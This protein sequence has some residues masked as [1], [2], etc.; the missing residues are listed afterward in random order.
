MASYTWARRGDVNC[1]FGLMLDNLA[2]M[3]ILVTTLAGTGLFT[4]SFILT[5]MIPGTALGVLIGDLVFTWLAFRLARRTGRADVTAM[6][7]GLDTPSTFGVALLVL[8][9]A[10]LHA[11]TLTDDPQRAMEFAWHVGLVTLV[12]S[13]IFKTLLAPLG[14]AVRRLFPRAGL[15]G[16]LAAIALTLIAFLPLLLDGIAAVPLVGMLALAVILYTLVAHRELPG[17]FPGALGAVVLGVAVYWLCFALGEGTGVPLVPPPETPL[18][19]EPWQPASLLAFYQSDPSWLRDVFGY[20]LGRLPVALPFALATI[21][22]GIDCTESAAAAGDDYDT[23]GILMTEGLASLAAGLLGGVIQTTPYIGHPAYKKMGG[24]AAYTLANALF[25]GVAGCVGGFTYLYA[26]LPTAAMFGI[27]VF[28][29]L[30]ITAQSFHA[31][32]QRHYPAVAFAMLPALAYLITVPFNNVTANLELLKLLQ[33]P[34]PTTIAPG[35]DHDRAARLLVLVQT[36]RCLANGFL[37]SGMLWA[38]ALAMILDGRLRAAAAFFLV[39]GLGAFFGII[40]SPLQ[41]EQINLPWRVLEQMQEQTPAFYQA[42]QHQTPWHW[43]GAYALVALLLFGL[44][45]GE[46]RKSPEGLVLPAA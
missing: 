13:G 1:F 18:P 23:R 26:F 7:L 33:W 29:G 43:A 14:N 15:L 28:V 6:P 10:R 3:I 4:A 8:I 41:A 44:S 25:V 34:D 5:R 35:V 36:L 31:T 40:H 2:V 30:E 39:A 37:I 24:T 42:V 9:P 32:P 45:F 16:S 19:P 12:L 27:F 11:N 17:R 21:V 38:A 20:A 46:R 22:G